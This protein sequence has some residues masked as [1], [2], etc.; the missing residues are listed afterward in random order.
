MNKERKKKIYYNKQKK[1]LLT[2]VIK[3]KMTHTRNTLL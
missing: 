1:I 2:F 3:I